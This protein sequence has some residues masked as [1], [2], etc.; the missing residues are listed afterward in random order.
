MACTLTFGENLLILPETGRHRIRCHS[1]AGGSYESGFA[2]AGVAFKSDRDSGAIQFGEAA[3]A[4]DAAVEEDLDSSQ[5]IDSNA[6]KQAQAFEAVR[7]R[8]LFSLLFVVDLV[9]VFG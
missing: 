7:L 3:G 4:H 1:I 2:Q 5:L 8:R 6:V 9:G